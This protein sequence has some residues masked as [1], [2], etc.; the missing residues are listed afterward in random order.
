MLQCVQRAWLPILL[1]RVIRGQHSPSEASLK[2]FLLTAESGTRQRPIT[3][4]I[5]ECLVDVN[6]MKKGDRLP[7]DYA[8]GEDGEGM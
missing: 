7:A 8:D 4:A 1:I 6:G 3:D 2:A 5:P